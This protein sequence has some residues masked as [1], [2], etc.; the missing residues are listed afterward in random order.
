MSKDTI[1][2][3]GFHRL[4]E[5][6]ETLSAQAEQGTP[7]TL[8]RLKQ[9]A[10]IV[11]KMQS[12]YHP[13]Y[14]LPSGEE[15]SNRT[16]LLRRDCAIVE[17]EF[18]AI[19][20]KQQVRILDIGCN[21]GYVSFT[22]AQTFPNT[23]GLDISENHITLCNAIRAHTGSPAK[24][25]YWDMLELVEN[26]AADLENLDCVLLL[27][28]VHQLI[29]AKGIP[30]VKR[31]I[32]TLAASV[33]FL[34]VELATRADYVR[35]GKDQELPLDP[36]E[37]LE[38]CTDSTITL[39]HSSP[40]PIYT[41]RRRRL[42]VDGRSVDYSTR[43]YTDDPSGRTSR[44]YYFGSNTF[45]KVIRYTALDGPIKYD[46]E[47]HGLQT[48]QGLNVAPEPLAWDNDGR[49][50]RICMQRFYGPRLSTMIP[51]LSNRDK[52]SCL[53]EII[54]IATGLASRSLYQ[55]DFA[56]HNYIGLSDGSLRMVDFEQ[57]GRIPVR[58]PFGAFL[59][60]AHDIMTGTL[61]Y[62]REEMAR[63]LILNDTQK[64]RGRVAP[65]LYPR[66]DPTDLSTAFGTPLA[67]IVSE[68]RDT[69]LNWQSFIKQAHDRLAKAG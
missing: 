60:I 63:K 64:E 8:S 21:S 33:D 4:F 42:N 56:S 30:Y 7:E 19:Q 1:D 49:I 61:K 23:I 57:S 2:F 18:A 22:L 10:D 34:V 50:G 59:W 58:D 32:A 62:H 44:K 20:R 54:R 28:V 68:A 24:F 69:E 5:A 55:H 41:L 67:D 27:N 52:S 37:I 43:D 26:G 9:A 36:A 48:L 6:P 17:Q 35:H 31:F 14:G 51:K 39:I 65:D 47:L 66:L 12:S 46:S 15:A 53:R 25:Y 16:G 3:P 29:F 38:D 11:E 40:R 13:V 45:T